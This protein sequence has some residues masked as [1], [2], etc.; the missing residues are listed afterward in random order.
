[1]YAAEGIGQLR[2]CTGRPFGEE[3]FMEQMEERFGRRWRRYAEKTKTKI[4]KF[5]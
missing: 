3:S 1:M 5:A 2:K 4:A